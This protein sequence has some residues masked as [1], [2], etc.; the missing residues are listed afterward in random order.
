MIEKMYYDDFTNTYVITKDPYAAPERYVE[1]FRGSPGVYID[2]WGGEKDGQPG[3]ALSVAYTS[4]E[5]Y[6][7]EHAARFRLMCDQHHFKPTHYRY[8]TLPA[9]KFDEY[10]KRF[11]LES[12]GSTNKE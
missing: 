7:D 8:F 10:V 1:T 2:H 3:H 6:S 11:H 9:E 5:Y 12:S 4:D